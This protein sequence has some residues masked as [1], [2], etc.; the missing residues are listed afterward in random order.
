MWPW[1]HVASFPF[2]E[3]RESWNEAREHV[4]SGHTNK[5]YVDLVNG[6]LKELLDT[7]IS[8]PNKSLE[9]GNRLKQACHTDT[10]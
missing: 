4:G 2:C 3:N 6:F 10:V 1:E 8:F 7:D 5:I 9:I